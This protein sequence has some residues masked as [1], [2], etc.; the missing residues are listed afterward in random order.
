MSREDR[1]SFIGNSL[2]TSSKGQGG[3]VPQAEPSTSAKGHLADSTYIHSPTSPIASATHTRCH[4]YSYLVSI[5]N[6]PHITRTD[7]KLAILDLDSLM[8]HRASVRP[9]SA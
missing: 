2:Y 5:N 6:Q 9:A 7:H 1:V 4:P 8:T 3:G